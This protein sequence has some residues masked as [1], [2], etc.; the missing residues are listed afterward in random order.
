MHK[1]KIR[2]FI[3]KAVAVLL[4][5]LF[6]IDNTCYGLAP[7]PGA[8]NPATV[9]DFSLA[10]YWRNRLIR[11][12]E[13]AEE[14][15]LL[16]RNGNANCLL[17]SCG[18]Y[19][20]MPH[21]AGNN[22]ELLASI[23]HEDI[24]AVM[25]V[26]KSGILSSDDRYRY[27]AIK[28]LVLKYFP[29][30]K[31]TTRSL[32][33]Y[34]NH[35]VARMFQWYLLSQNHLISLNDIPAAEKGFMDRVA[36]SGIMEKR[37]NHFTAEFWDARERT[38]LI[39]QALNKGIS[40]Y[41]TADS[42]DE[43]D[44]IAPSGPLSALTFDVHEYVK[45]RIPA[46]LFEDC[47]AGKAS[48][49]L[50]VGP[51]GKSM[52]YL[53][54]LESAGAVVEEIG[55]E[56]GRARVFKITAG[57]TITY[58]V[59]RNIF[60]STRLEHYRAMLE[61]GGI[62]RDS[63]VVRDLGTKGEDLY[64]TLLGDQLAG[65]TGVVLTFDSEKF[66]GTLK[67]RIGEDAVSAEKNISHELF[68]G[69]VLTLKSG[70]RIGI[71]DLSTLY[72]TQA[73]VF[74]EWL[75][76]KIAGRGPP[77][78]W[79]F[80]YG[81][82]G[83]IDGK[84]NINDIVLPSGIYPPQGAAVPVKNFLAEQDARD[85]LGGDVAVL[86]GDVVSVPG[87]F[88]ETVADVER[89]KSEKRG[90]I[91]LEL[92]PIAKALRP[93]AS[94]QLNALFEVTDLPGQAG[95]HLAQGVP[96]AYRPEYRVRNREFLADYIVRHYLPVGPEEIEH[97]ADVLSGQNANIVFCK[98]FFTGHY[99]FRRGSVAL[100]IPARFCQAFR[101]AMPD[102]KE[103]DVE[104]LFSLRNPDG[105]AVKAAFKE[106]FSGHGTTNVAEVFAAYGIKV[107]RDF[108][109]ALLVAPYGGGLKEVSP[110]KGVERIAHYLIRN[111][112][113]TDCRVY[114]PNLGSPDELYALVGREK[115][116]MIGFSYMEVTL[117]ND[118]EILINTRKKCLNQ[119]AVVIVG[120]PAIASES[121]PYGE[122]FSKLP[123]DIFVKGPGE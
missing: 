27:G 76:A 58:A 59:V 13:T 86:S 117:K 73:G 21:I 22:R 31:R 1:K 97:A 16:S 122:F 43:E 39:R 18:K 75:A 47:L 2:L 72:G 83:G 56:S 40:F 62:K 92:F 68:R 24:E 9:Q 35:T 113:G 101:D 6:G 61:Y 91:E 100:D 23:I 50:H 34:V 120:G 106:Y 64:D 63:I 33:L 102:R 19:L 15:A 29:P 85:A 5:V 14:I 10:Y 48:C 52:E 81:A 77:L 66:A 78:K 17:L 121:F 49:E 115:F 112:E 103:K 44:T 42:S 104:M 107:L 57:D 71:F 60:G 90:A 51:T 20:V 12:A 37:A 25:Q 87:I 26:L 45:N 79:F 38:G 108:A 41:Q 82:C 54:G 32:D 69:S 84:L 109:K 28:D 123:I 55:R 98:N 99:C 119:D 74:T 30:D 118:M 7:I 94:T 80:V 93:Y 53:K 4:I 8:L 3:F 105:E 89:W 36:L 116:D 96:Q 67:A 114:N 111:M 95:K 110:H 11:V 65:L 46:C 70:S 88:A